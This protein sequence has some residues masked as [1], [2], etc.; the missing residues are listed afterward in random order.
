[1]SRDVNNP[2]LGRGQRAVTGPWPFTA[3]GSLSFFK[4]RNSTYTALHKVHQ[5]HRCTSIIFDKYI[6]M[7]LFK[8]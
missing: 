6:H 4:L 2:A 7:Y 1:M 3:M 8:I 5:S